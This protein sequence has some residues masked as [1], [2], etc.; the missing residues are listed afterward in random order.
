MGLLTGE[1]R[2][3]TVRATTECECLV[4][5]HGAFDE[6]LRESTDLVEKMS[7]L[8]ARRQAELDV[9]A[10]ERRDD[11]EPMQDRSRRLISQIKDFFK[12]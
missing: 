8:I 10:S 6:T 7:D 12:L 11:G 2:T 9:V 5:G 1:R 3:A 4:I